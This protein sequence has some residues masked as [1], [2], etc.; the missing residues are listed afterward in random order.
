MHQIFVICE[1]RLKKNVPETRKDEN[2][3]ILM[4]KE[5][6]GSD[7]WTVDCC[8]LKWFLLYT[9]PVTNPPTACQYSDN[10]SIIFFSFG[11][12]I[13]ISN[14]CHAPTLLLVQVGKKSKTLSWG[15][16]IKPLQWVF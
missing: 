10:R 4:K 7:F 3:K 11:T 12:F 15:F 2:R 14:Y 6:N 16:W 13:D 5:V 9:H 8:T 1:S